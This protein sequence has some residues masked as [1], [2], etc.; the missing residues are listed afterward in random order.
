MASFEKEPFSMNQR[1]D[2]VS[3]WQKGSIIA[4]AMSLTD[5]NW[6]YDSHNKA[7]TTQ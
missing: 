6:Y 1:I 5:A 2:L 3:I 4:R 7:L